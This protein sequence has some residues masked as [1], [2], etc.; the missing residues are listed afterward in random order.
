RYAAGAFTIHYFDHR[1]PVAPRSYWLI[2]SQ[3]LDELEKLLEPGAAA[4]LEY[5]SILTALKNLPAR[6]ETDPARLAERQREKEVIKRRL[7]ALTAESFLVRDFIEETLTLFNGKAGDPASFNLLEQLLDAQAYR[8]AYWRVAAD[9]INYRRFF[10]VNELAALSMERPEVFHAA[11]QL[12]FRLLWDGKVTGVRIDHPDGLYDP[13]EDL[14]RLQLH[15]ALGWAR[16]LY[17]T[18]PEFQ[19]TAWEELAGPLEARLRDSLRTPQPGTAALPLYVVVEKILTGPEALPADWQTD[20]TTGYEF[21]NQINGLFVDQRLSGAFTRLYR[22]WTD[23]DTR[24]AEFIYQNKR[25]ILQ[26]ALSS[27]LLMLSHQLDRLAQRKRWSRDFTTHSLRLA[28]REIIACFPV[29]RSYIV[30]VP[31]SASD[32]QYVERAVRR[33][34]LRNPGVSGA[35]FRYVRDMLLLRSPEVND[36]PYH[37][38]VR[39]FV[40]KFQQVTSPVMAKGVEDTSFYVWHPLLSLNEVGGEPDRFGVLPVGL[41][42]FLQERRQRWPWGL[43]STATHDTKRGEDVRARIN[44]LSEMPDDW[45]EALQRWSKLNQRHRAEVD[46]TPAPD[47]NGEYLIYQTLLGVWPNEPLDTAEARE[48]FVQ[49]IQGYLVKALHEAKVHSSWINPNEAYDTAVCQFAARILDPEVSAEFLADFQQLQRR[50]RHYGAFNSLGQTLLKIAA[51]GVPDVYQGTELWDLS[52]VDPD[53]RRPVDYEARQRYLSELKEQVATRGDDLRPLAREL[54][55][56]KDD[57]RIKLYLLWRGLN[58]RRAHAGLFT[59]GEYLPLEPAGALAD[60][61]FGFVR[62]AGDQLALA[63]VPR[64]LTR[65]L[66]TE[67][68]PCG[69]LIWKDTALKLP[70]EAKGLRWRNVFT[71]AVLDGRSTSDL[72]MSQV[73]ADFPVALLLAE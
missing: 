11:H 18:R 34:M 45:S 67:Q 48:Q 40:G 15:F 37:A 56:A 25:L 57:G 63:A 50:V 35:L 42:G 68:A 33:A 38:E 66:T 62:R 43:S 29:Y 26:I 47:A 72:P 64:L 69:T 65:V 36:A 55:A 31:V 21:L 9:E 24:F 8:L 14:E 3:R 16:K 13:R 44:V 17:A 12:I 4:L 23:D 71:G 30:D 60:H 73:C 20:G 41:H 53:N 61:V 39:R 32:Q 28:L 5:Q 22:E 46:E 7:A 19:H 10:D 70:A 27:E 2:L 6:T 1:F 51:P 52:L 59:A 49:R 58:Y 54:T